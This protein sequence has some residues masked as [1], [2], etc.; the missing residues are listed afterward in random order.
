MYFIFD[1]SSINNTEPR[2]VP[3]EG[4]EASNALRDYAERWRHHR[5]YCWGR[6]CVTSP[7]WVW[8]GGLWLCLILLL[9]TIQHLLLP[10]ATSFCLLR[11]CLYL[12][13]LLLGHIMVVQT[14]ARSQLWAAN[15]ILIYE[16]LCIDLHTLLVLSFRTEVEFLLNFNKLTV[17]EYDWI[18]RQ[19]HTGC[20]FLTYKIYFKIQLWLCNFWNEKWL[21]LSPMRGL[22][23]NQNLLV[24]TS[25]RPAEE[26]K[27]I[28]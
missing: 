10:I 26:G 9:L 19:L 3:L 18:L 13:L 16:L 17:Y 15:K 4:Y 7:A 23:S 11:L 2:V 5:R 20:I 14:T 24:V 12:S 8:S 28:S 22:V 1:A 21:A 25:M 6:S 27:T